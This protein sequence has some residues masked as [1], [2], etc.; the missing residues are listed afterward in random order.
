MHPFDHRLSPSV[1]AKLFDAFD[2]VLRE[3]DPQMRGV[4]ARDRSAQFM[5]A[6][7]LIC[8]AS[9]GE[10]DPLVFEALVRT[11]L[12]IKAPSRDCDISPAESHG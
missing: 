9:S 11:A 4:V 6:Q 2:R 7:S 12:R 10:R 5:A 8:A 1:L 3:L